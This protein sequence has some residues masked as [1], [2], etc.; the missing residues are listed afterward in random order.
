VWKDLSPGLAVSRACI[1]PVCFHPDGRRLAVLAG[2]TVQLREVDRGKTIATFQHPGEIAR[3]AWRSDGQVFATGCFD[4]DIYLWDVAN[5]AQPLRILKGHGAQ[6]VDVA[7]SRGGDRLLSGAWDSTNR[8][9]DAITG[10]LLVS[11]PVRGE[12]QSHHFGPDDRGREHGWQVATGRECRTFHGSKRLKRIALCP[13]GRLA[14]ST[15][16]A[17]VQLWDLAAA[18]EGDKLLGTLPIESGMQVC[19]DPRGE[20]LITSSKPAGLQ[21]WP[22]T[23]DAKAGVLRIGPPQPLGQSARSPFCG[24]EFDFALSADG[25]TVAYS[26]NPGQ[27]LLYDLANPRRK[28]LIES[29]HLR[30]LAFSPDGRWLATGNWHGRCVKVWDT[31][32]GKLEA[33]PDLG[34]SPNG[35]AWPTFSP[36]GKWL[37]T[38]TSAEYRIWEV[39]SWQRNLIVP[40][41]KAARDHGWSA[42][43]PD[44]KLLALSHLASEL[45]LV[46]PVTGREF[47]RLPTGAPYGFSADGSQLVTN[48]G[49]GDSFHVW[50]LRLIRRQLREMDLDWNLP[51]YPPPPDEVVKPLRVTVLPAEPLSPSKQLDAEA[52]IQRGLVFMQLRRIVSATNDFIQASALDPH[53]RPPWEDCLREHARLIEREPK[54]VLH[55]RNRGHVY[56]HL[57]KHAEGLADYSRA[58]DLGPND[59]MNWHQ[60]GNTHGQ[61]GEW[62][63]ALEDHAKAAELAP[64]NWVMCRGHGFACAQVGQWEKAL[65][66]FRHATTLKSDS[67]TVWYYL[68]MLELQRGDRDGYRKACTEMLARHGASAND[69]APYWIAWTCVVAPEAVSDWSKLLKLA[70]QATPAH[71]KNFERINALGA[72]LYRA[73]RFEE[74]AHRLAEAE[75]A[76]EQTPGMKVPLAYNWLFLAMVHHRLGDATEAARWLE[77]AVRAIDDPPPEVTRQPNAKSWNRLLTLQLLRREAEELLGKKGP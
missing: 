71:E 72:V 41:D 23:L 9:W 36:D 42:F 74:A 17:G 62:N 12:H 59:A 40:R 14:A 31:R 56:L 50:D 51:P 22:M 46:D 48:V 54:S 27:L 63:K 33:D 18:C 68:A 6:V 29:P 37:L 70:Q 38:G 69:A 64:T 67:P 45:R 57:G 28:R 65:T 76:F 19:F 25:G 66:L 55:R 3:L 20:N 7:F 10:Q 26:P 16:E 1:S 8:L 43:A 2:R 13:K 39:G 30:R 34:R 24:G 32:T 21:R 49:K 61:I 73:G 5:P 4:D 75:A 77:K 52:L 53:C 47:A 35:S 44:S 60:R 11:T 58:I 15:C